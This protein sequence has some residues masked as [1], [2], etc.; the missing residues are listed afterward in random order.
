MCCNVLQVCRVDRD[1]ELYLALSPLVVCC[2]VLQ[3]VEVR[4]S[5]FQCVAVCCSMSGGP[6]GQAVS[7]ALSPPAVCCKV[8]QC[9]AVCCRVLQCVDR[10]V[11]LYL[12]L[13]PVAVCFSVLHD[14]VW[15]CV[16]VSCSVLQC[17]AACCSVLQ[18]VAV[19]HSTSP[20]LL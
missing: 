10:D 3:C 20:S 19:C 8:L 17:V 11:E 13:S 6:R 15:P 18:R 2:T 14:S 5:V 12:A 7:L 1:F 4:S 9:V 16:A